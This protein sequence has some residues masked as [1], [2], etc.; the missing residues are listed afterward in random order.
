MKTTRLSGA[1]L[2]LICLSLLCC[3]KKITNI[4][5][6][7][8]EVNLGTY[9]LQHPGIKVM[10]YENKT[11]AVFR[12]SV[13]NLDTFAISFLSKRSQNSV[14]PYYDNKNKDAR[15]IYCYRC[16]GFKC[17]LKSRR[18]KVEFTISLAAV[19]LCLAECKLCPDK[20][21]RKSVDLLSVYVVDR[22][23]KSSPHILLFHKAIDTEPTPSDFWTSQYLPEIEFFDRKFQHVETMEFTDNAP[24]IDR[25][26][27]KFYYSTKEGIVAF[28]MKNDVL[29]RLEGL[30]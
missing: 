27:S 30:Y 10:P 2:L 1:T 21:S 29:W 26:P 11:F 18:T 14:Y 19:P 15:K 8:C 22:K 9:K 5:S 17:Y 16:Q 24:V 23:L 20:A 7:V 28:Q 12:D 6:Y 3:T 25:Q 4:G 13:G